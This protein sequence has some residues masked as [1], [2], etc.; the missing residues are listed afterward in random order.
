[1]MTWRL[2]FCWENWNF[3]RLEPYMMDS[4]KRGEREKS[5]Q[6]RVVCNNILKEIGGG[7]SLNL[8][9]NVLWCA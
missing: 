7:S 3:F 2:W 6:K 1:M 5:V 9:E 8:N 4:E